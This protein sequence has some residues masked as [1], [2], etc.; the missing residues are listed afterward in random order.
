MAQRTLAADLHAALIAGHVRAVFQPVF[1]AFG[2]IPV[3]C[4]T[5]ARWTHPTLGEIAPEVFV[6][7]ASEFATLLDL[8][9]FGHA[10][11]QLTA[12]GERSPE[13]ISVNVT[14]ES[15]RDPGFVE[16]VDAVVR[17]QGHTLERFCIEINERD[18]LDDDSITNLHRL[19]GLGARLSLDDLGTGF[20]ALWLVNRLEVDELKIDKTFIADLATNDRS[21][22]IVSALVAVARD[23]DLQIEAEGVES[24]AA[25][26]IVAGLGVTRMQ[27]F[28]LARP[29]HGGDLAFPVRDRPAVAF[30]PAGIA[31]S[32]AGRLAALRAYRIMDTEPEAAFD[33]LVQIAA[34]VCGTSKAMVN[35]AD[36]ARLWFKSTIG[37][38][39]SESSRQDSFCDHVIYD[40]EIGASDPATHGV[41]VVEDASE[42]PRFAGNPNAAGPGGVR[43]YAGAPLVSGDG[44]AVGTLCVFDSTPKRLTDA[45]LGLLAAL[46]E[47][48]VS[49]LEMRTV[50]AALAAVVESRATAEAALLFEATHDHLTGLANRRLFFSTLQTLSESGVPFGVVFVDLDGFK[51]VNDRLGHADGDAHLQWC[52][53][54][55]SSAVRDEDIVARI[56]GD[57]FAVIV[58]GAWA[59][60][61][62]IANRTRVA[63]ARTFETDDGIFT[64][65]GSVGV[66][67]FRPGGD[68]ELLLH[69]ADCQMYDEKSRH[70]NASEGTFGPS[71]R[72]A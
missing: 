36:G 47:Q 28:H 18:R 10:A 46:A 54:G 70:R 44:H 57:E 52:A 67:S 49:Q 50:S 26:T 5:L 32:E 11:A 55:L 33:Q 42:D 17:A 51:Q 48:V 66:S 2:R 21:R 3:G 19:R 71:R 65:G 41:L 37:F 35:F 6:P 22:A 8:T 24:E 69:E 34:Q 61:A 39:G 58:P 53:E 43:M 60:L 7:A 12:W 31:P 14:P 30:R 9:M 27:G 38:P 45:Q 1:S 40:H 16:S 25:A 72:T 15:L 20:A 13:R 59:D 62:T 56:G 68:L 64:V 23:L 63:L 29:T 4:E